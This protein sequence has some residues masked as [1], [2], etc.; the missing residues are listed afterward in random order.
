MDITY[1][2]EKVVQIKRR[3]YNAD[4]I[5]L[6]LMTIPFLL[7]VIAFS[8]VPLFGWVY[9]FFDYKPG[10]PLSQT[11]FVGL[12]HF[13]E[14]LHDRDMG[15]V[16]INTLALSVLSILF[17]PLPLV[18]AI[19]VSEVRN[20]FFKRLIQTTTTLPNYISWIIVFSLAFSMFSSEGAINTA[21]DRLGLSD[22]PLNVLGNADH[23]WLVQTLLLIWKTIGWNAII[24]LAAI[25]GIDGEQYDAAR[26][27][28]AG[29]LRSIWYITIPNIMPTFIVLL[30][31]AVSNLL[32][33][34]FEQYLVFNNIMVADKIEVL[35]LYVYRLGLVTNDY[36]YSTAVGMFK[37]VISIALLFMINSL[38]KR[39]RGES[40]I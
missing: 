31:L 28:G 15:R 16:M 25:V 18:L 2:K 24:Y 19:M 29:R 35:D 20:G 3:K 7:F 39:V 27:D 32:S 33:A 12:E 22:T 14:M 21:I 6:L 36:P 30:L 38:S 4:G 17:A 11:A 1:K 40:I 13:R 23:V 9:A 37:S 10:I 5:R 34:G 8:Y 26:I